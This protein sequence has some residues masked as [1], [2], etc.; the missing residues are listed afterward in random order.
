VLREKVADGGLEPEVRRVIES[1]V[2][3]LGEL[4]ATTREISIPIVEN[5]GA[6]SKCI[7]DMDGATV[8]YERLKTRVAEYDHNTRVRLLTGILTP[9]QHYFKSQKLRGL[10]RN[11]ILELLESVDV[12]ALATSPTPAPV[13]PE[14]AGTRSKEEAAGRIFGVRNYTGPFNLANL[15]ALA[16]PCGF[17][18]ND[19][20]ISLQIAGRAFEDDTIMK[21]AHAYEQA[22]DW[23]TRRAPV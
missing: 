22:T 21:V 10:L 13:L 14:A 19:L 1:A 18:S 9:A 6:V 5:A 8:H 11:Q 17:T 7:T 16:V 4:G 20:P 23:H 15:P 2:A 3:L 12:L